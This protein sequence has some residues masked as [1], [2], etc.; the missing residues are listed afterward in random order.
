[1][2]ENSKLVDPHAARE[3]EKYAKPIPSR[4]LI[5]DLLNNSVGP[6]SHRELCETLGI[7][8]DEGIEAL[9]R[10]LS[11]MV[12]DGQLASNRRGGYGTLDK[13][14]LLKGRVV[15]HPDGFG[16]VV[17]GEPQDV[18]LSSRQMRRVF[19]GDEVLVRIAGYDQRGRPEGSI[20]E[21]VA[22]NTSKLVGRYFVESGVCFVRPDNPRIGQDIIIPPDQAGG[23]QSGQM[24]VVAITSQPSRQHL[25]MGRIAQVLGEYRAPGMEIQLSLHNYNIPHEWPAELDAELEAIADEVE[26]ADK[27]ARVDLRHLPFVTIDGEDAKDFDDAVYCE[28]LKK[29]GWRRLKGGWRLLVAIADV[30]HYVR[31]G[32][33]LDEEA[34]KRGTS[35][36]F[37]GQVV[38]MLPEKL[39]NGLCSLNPDVDRL[40]MVCEMTVL[41]NGEIKDYQF[42]EAVMHSRARLTYTQVAGMIAQRDDPNSAVRARFSEIVEHIDHL[43]DLYQALREARELRGAIDFETGETRILFDEHRKIEQIIPQV[44]T[45]AHMLIEEC[46]LAANVCAASLLEKCKIPALYRVHN[47]PSEEKLE[48]LREFL[49]ELGL[50]LGGGLSPTPM[51]YQKVLAQVA[52]RPDA[53]VIQQV[54]LR[55]MSRAEYQPANEGHFGLNYEAYTHFTSPIRRYPDLLVHRAIRSLLRSRK[56][57][58][59]LLRAEGATPLSAAEAYP[60]D[61]AWMEKA[62][63]HTSFTERR[64]DEA[65][66]DVETWLKCEYLLDK[67]GEEFTGV[68][69]S[70]VGFGLFVELEDLFVEGLIHITGLPKDYYYFEAA[71]HR[72]VG[73]RTRKVFRLGDRVRVRVTRVDLEERKVDFEL[74]EELDSQ[75]RRKR[76]DSTEKRSGAAKRSAGRE[77]N[78]KRKEKGGATGRKNSQ[79]SSRGGDRAAAKGNKQGGSRSSRR[80]KR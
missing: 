48:R 39:S 21:V 27:R 68:V 35:V 78:D 74:L 6:L 45:R 47:G 44:R 32:S 1:M 52:G 55:S 3:A 80:R 73:E 72:L 19:D 67:V 5:L 42:F 15:G 2:K 65:T 37:P 57:S 24:V 70:V 8:D 33:A 17:T 53:H 79:G 59:H 38:P 20:V 7:E 77:T 60:Y 62:G 26:E 50:G 54:M 23:A 31:P 29:G 9:R 43:H 58:R 69:S 66:R 40:C 56:R 71:H 63:E 51:D 64:A 49:A 36:Y 12:R 41:P 10:R 14:S 13:M 76:H 75:P 28:P 25:P 34:W 46:M 18:Y 16:F 30:S 11:A 4:E 22:H 61:Q